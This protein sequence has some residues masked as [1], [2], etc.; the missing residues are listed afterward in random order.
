MS[1]LNQQEPTEVI[2]VGGAGFIGRPLVRQLSEAGVRVSIVDRNEP[3]DIGIPWYSCDLLDTDGLARHLE[4]ADVVV[5]LV[6]T[7]GAEARPRQEYDALNI[8]GAHSVCAASHR[9]GVRRIVFTSSAA[10]YGHFDNPSE[11]SACRPSGGYGESK[12]D[13][14]AIYRSW[15]DESPERELAVVRPTV[16]FGQNGDGAGHRLLAQAVARRGVLVA[17]SRSMKS[18]AFVENLAAFLTF[19]ALRPARDQLFNYSDTPDLTLDEI[20]RIVRTEIGLPP[21]PSVSRLGA[22]AA[23]ARASLSRRLR[24]SPRADSPALRARRASREIRFDATAAHATE[25]QQPHDL[26]TALAE[27]A[28]F[29]FGWISILPEEQ[30]P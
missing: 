19:V 11:S 26:R 29:E 15:R 28:R 14:E 16:V 24:G 12:R 8:G 5:N 18:L 6:A 7:H 25:F 4:G 22:M 9:A 13:A 10:V 21:A 30:R 1:Y 27:V 3:R 17:G 2:V 23:F 20:Y